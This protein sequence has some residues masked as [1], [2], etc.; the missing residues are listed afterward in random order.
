[1]SSSNSKL[2]IIL[3]IIFPT[4]FNVVFFSIAGTN[5]TD[6]VWVSYI[7]I[8]ISYAMYLII[9]ALVNKY[10]LRA[11]LV[12]PLYLISTVYFYIEL[13]VGIAFIYLRMENINP[14]FMIQIIIFGIFAMILISNLIANNNTHDSLLKHENEVSYIKEISSRV[15]ALTDQM[16]D[17]E[18]NRTIE[19]TYDLLHTCPAKS[20]QTVQPLEQRILNM[21]QQ[22][23]NAVH[24]QKREQVIEITAKIQSTIEE[25]NRKLK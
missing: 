10:A 24:E 4:I 23:E 16:Q 22:L 12:Q 7:F 19:R 8:H 20:D 9:H 3:I 1:M 14:A 2:W 11:E 15:Y 21:V 6:S 25:R 18:A 17:K 13:A 5:H